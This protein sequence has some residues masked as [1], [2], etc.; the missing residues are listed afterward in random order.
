MICG[1]TWVR[2]VGLVLFAGIILNACGGGSGGADPA[3]VRNV[4]TLSV[5]PTDVT[6]EALGASVELEATAR[7]QTGN[8]LSVQFSWS[9]S[10]TSIVTVDADG[11]VTAVANGTA[12]VTARSDSVSASATVTVE[13][14]PSRIALSRE[15]VVLTALGITEGLEASVFDAN[16][17]AM[18]GELVWSSSDPAVVAVDGNGTITSQANGTATVSV[19]IGQVSGLAAVTVQQAVSTIRLLPE[20]VTLIAIDQRAVLEATALDANGHAV[21]AE[22]GYTSSEPAVATVDDTGQLIARRNGVT[23]VTATTGTVSATVTVTVMQVLAGIVLVP[24]VIELKAIGETAQLQVMVVDAN[25]IPMTADVSL[26]SSDPAVVSVNADGLVTA[27]ANGTATITA[28][29]GSVS[30]TASVTVRQVLES[31]ALAPD[32]VELAA[33]DASVQL[34]LTALDANGT[35]MSAEVSFTSSDPAVASVNAD[36]LVTAQ[37]NG[38]ATITA[39]SGSVSSTATVAVRQVLESIALAPDYV[40]LAAIDEI[41]QLQV[42]ALDANGTPMS[43]EVS[44]TSSDPAVASVNADGLVT[45]QANGTATITAISGSVSSTATVAVMQVLERITLAPNNVELAAIGESAQLQVTALDANGTPISAEVNFS[46]SDPA[47]VS[48][49]AE[50]LVTARANGTAI[51]TVTSDSMSASATV[52]V[53]QQVASV[54]L[55]PVDT[56]T[57]GTVGA[58]VQL[59]A[60]ARDANGHAVIV[61]FVWVSSDPSV[62]EVDRTG[63]VTAHEDG[64]TEI[65]ASSGGFSDA[66]ALELALRRAARIVLTPP[67]SLLQAFDETVQLSVEVLDADGQELSAPVAWASSDPGIAAV[68]ASGLITARGNGTATITARNGEASAT[69]TV[70]VMQRIGRLRIS[71]QGK[72]LDPLLFTSLGE[73][74][75]F[76]AEALDPNGHAISGAVFTAGSRNGGIVGIDDRLLATAISNGDTVIDFD[77]EWAGVVTRLANSVRVRQVA[78]GLEIE[79]AARTFRSIGETHRFLASA[80]DANGHALS[81]DSLYWESTD[82]RVADVD[83]TGVVS[84]VGVGETAVTVSSAEGLSASATVT[85]DLQAMCGAGDRTPSIASVVPETLVEGTSFTIQGLGF[86]AESAGNLVTVDRMIAAVEV[87]SETRL[88]V[89]VPQFDCLPSRGVEVSVAVGRNRATRDVELKPDE[90]VV[91]V[92]VGRQTIWGAG[93][94]KCLQFPAADNGEAY[95]IG[96]QSTS[97]EPS[98]KL[99]PVRLIGS[100]SQAGTAAAGAAER[101]TLSWNATQSSMASVPLAAN[102]TELDRSPSDDLG[103]IEPLASSDMGPAAADV[104]VFPDRGDIGS[105]PEEGDVVMIPNSTATWVVHKVGAHA[106]WLV[107]TDFV[108][109]LEA[110]YASQ[111]KALSEAFD[112]LIY[113]VVSDYFGAPDLGAIGR[114]VVVV[115]TESRTANPF[116]KGARQWYGITMGVRTS[117][118]VLAHEF[119]HV[120]QA[121]GAAGG[122]YPRSRSHAAWYVE[123]Q[124]QLGVEQY[125]LVQSNRTT[126]QNYGSSVAFDRGS[127]HGIGWHLNFLRLPLF[128]GGA[129]PERPQECSWLRNDAA[130]CRGSVLFYYVGW[131]LLRWLTDQYGRLYPGGEANLHRELNHG[132]DGLIETIEKHMGESMETLLA[133]WAAALYVDDRIPNLDPD[134]QFTTWNFYD[135]FR[136]DPDRLMPLEI[137]FSDQEHRARIRDGSF[138]YVQL[139]GSQRPATAIRV[140]NLADRDL[141]DDMQVWI[142][143]L[144]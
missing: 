144:R 88:S 11:R 56:S 85:G 25:G 91:S 70:R 36:G 130:P 78:V 101:R 6:L 99:T 93:E 69:A 4:S 98:D 32:N 79:P 142:V 53:D 2:T 75:Q 138:W 137:G 118:D 58:T 122:P 39:I 46:S 61:E 82:R 139:S 73:T 77:V 34:Q 106:L 59:E 12:T 30:S 109:R 133:R 48:V 83:M 92:A 86:C 52:T 126:G 3:P 72:F 114:V 5:S 27:R 104:I 17:N 65:R 113:P 121:A 103:F 111:F 49:N 22:I 123:G 54:S 135:I 68:G 19:T 24:G 96:V 40:E 7:D 87:L 116:S 9:S 71:P 38:T 140:R 76:T 132:P 112:E 1:H 42:T 57:L 110:L 124:A 15:E 115:G 95:L 28:I 63:L 67:S 31:I 119:V 35:P 20:T 62:A 33:I 107:D 131:S 129:H 55:A 43:A 64:R 136:D 94:D 120:V 66:L 29:S 45:A 134:L 97:L 80:R 23:T 100:S 108:E 117:I 125:T 128:F 44:F 41:V 102:S 89:T 51:V 18:S 141:S 8:P 50:G 81:A 143:R 37:A 14:A 47:V 26:S 84:I 60:V 16:D 21:A 127:A 90:P 74:V 13:Q 10:D 105:L